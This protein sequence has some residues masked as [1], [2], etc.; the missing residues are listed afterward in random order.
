[1][2]GIN[3]YR[4]FAGYV[5]RLVGLLPPPTRGLR[6]C[7][8]LIYL[9]KYVACL[10]CCAWLLSAC[11]KEADD[12]TLDFGEDLYPLAVGSEY[13]YA[14]DSVIYDPL[15]A[16]ERI[17]T[18]TGFS[19]EVITEIIEGAADDTLY[20]LER[21]YRRTT[22]APWQVTDVWTVRREPTRLIR[23]EEN[24]DFIKL[25]FP[26]TERSDWDALAFFDENREVLVAGE[27]I[28][29]FIQWDAEVDSIVATYTE[30]RTGFSYADAVF[31]QIADSGDNLLEYRDGVEVY[32]PNVGL[33]YRE[34]FV[35]DTQC[36]GAD[37]DDI[38]WEVKAEKGFIVRQSLLEFR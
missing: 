32:A 6:H 37:C 3:R 7:R 38:P 2:E 29:P 31:V 4:P 26:L 1:M 28:R 13:I 27:T 17:D 12:F 15:G 8:K 34:L 24:L 18:V 25:V 20:R 21:S 23:T 19:R 16:G 36:L 5:C 9:M 11:S 33:V 30:P 14:V 35:L 22:D 10:L